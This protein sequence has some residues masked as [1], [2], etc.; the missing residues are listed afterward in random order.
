[1]R[2]IIVVD[3]DNSFELGDRTHFENDD[4]FQEIFA[5]CDKLIGKDKYYEDW[6]AFSETT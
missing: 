4:L 2:L 3:Y 6:T 1:V 5:A